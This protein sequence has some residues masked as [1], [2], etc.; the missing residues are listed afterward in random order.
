MGIGKSSSITPYI[1]LLL[2]NYFINLQ[3]MYNKEIFIVMPYFLINQSFKI[4]LNN[5]FSIFKN[6]DIL[7]NAWAWKYK[8]QSKS[9][10]IYKNDIKIWNIYDNQ[11]KLWKLIE[12]VKR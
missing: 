12:N 3:K 2:L 6:V 7:L 1:C 4:L 8:H 9:L 5:L 11:W 10:T